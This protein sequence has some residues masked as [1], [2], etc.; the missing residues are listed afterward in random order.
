[1][2]YIGK[3]NLKIKAQ[4]LRKKGFSVKDI[5]NELKVSRSSVSLWIRNIELTDK[6][7]KRLYFSK[8]SGA[9][10]GSIKAAINK[11]RKREKI[12]KELLEKGI[13]EIGYLSE[14]DKF[15]I[16]IALY[17][18]EGTKADSSVSFSNSDS[19]AIFFMTSWLRN[20]CNVPESRFRASLYLHDNLNEIKAKKFWS[21][22]TKIP[23]KQFNKTYIVKNN[24][25]RLRKVRHIY[26]VLKITVSDVNLHRKIIGWIEGIFRH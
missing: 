14:R 25:R 1:M 4:S 13:S 6:Q 26:G 17:F 9:L 21:D 22:L 12:T 10:K 19:R 24:P 16:G 23:L 11:R 8:R 2:V 20:V 18:A 15:I 5:Q 7:L 3:L